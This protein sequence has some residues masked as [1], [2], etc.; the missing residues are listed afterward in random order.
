MRI[1][2]G[3]FKGMRLGTLPLK[4]LKPID[5]RVK[6]SLFNILASQIEGKSICDLFAGS[7]AI[8]LEALS[9][10]AE[11]VCFVE[12]RREFQKLLQQNSE[13]LK[14]QDQ[15]EIWPGDVFEAIKRFHQRKRQFDLIFVDP[16][17]FDRVLI[18]ESGRVTQIEGI[19]KPKPEEPK[20]L[21]G[22]PLPQLLLNYLDSYPIL[23]DLGMGVIRTFKK[24]PI[25]YKD[26]KTLK[27]TRLVQYG[28]A[29]LSFFANK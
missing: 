23:N 21:V 3:K 14:V 7:G 20:V 5:D 6:E 2:T 12:K 26:C 25:D 4:Q 29:L 22:E 16:P 8:G 27:Q 15:C 1:I 18:N 17:Y 19:R 13:K 10:G 11:N 28:D 9:R 24:I